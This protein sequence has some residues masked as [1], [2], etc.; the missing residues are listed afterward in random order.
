MGPTFFKCFSLCASYNYRPGGFEDA[1]QPGTAEDADAERLHDPRV[2][3]HR[4]D[5]AA[6]D[7][8]TVE[9]IEQRHRVAVQTETVQLEQHLDREQ[10]HE[11]Q[12][13]DLCVADNAAAAVTGDRAQTALPCPRAL[14]SA[15]AAGLGRA[16]PARWPE[17]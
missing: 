9:P 10:T 17:K 3:Q 1:Q 11:E 12:V 5:D 16:A 2:G 4:L 15:A 7:D 6:D 14:D 8:E 13:R